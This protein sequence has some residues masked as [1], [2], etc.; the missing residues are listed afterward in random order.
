[1][2]LPMILLLIITPPPPPSFNP[3]NSFQSLFYILEFLLC[4]LCLYRLIYFSYEK[5]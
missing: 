2:L 5:P 1:M 4:A 3:F